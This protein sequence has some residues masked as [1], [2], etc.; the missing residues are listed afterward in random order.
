MGGIR[1]RRESLQ[2]GEFEK[3]ERKEIERYRSK[4]YRTDSVLLHPPGKRKMMEFLGMKHRTIEVKIKNFM[5]LVGNNK[6]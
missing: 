2:C 1:N 5:I 4:E 6:R 3:I